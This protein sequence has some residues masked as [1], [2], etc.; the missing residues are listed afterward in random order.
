M[1]RGPRQSR[2]VKIVK[3]SG[4]RG[5]RG[6]GGGVNGGGGGMGEGPRVKIVAAKA[7]TNINRTHS[8]LRS[9]FRVI[10]LGDIDLQREIQLHK[11][12][13]VASLR[14]LHSARVEGKASDV[15][16]AVYQG[17]RGEEEWRRDIARYKA[18]RHPNIV[19]LYGAVSCGDIHAVVFHDDLIPFQQ[20]LDLYRHSH[21]SRAYIHVYMDAEFQAVEDYFMSAFE[22][23]LVN[24]IVLS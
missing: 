8:T 14:R 24:S 20:F 6:G 17:D 21:F 11:R 23:S 4:G 7:V 22:H 9:D 16:V 10:P 3:I 13:G 5:G 19:Q 18:V 1:F 15:T 2:R 12:S